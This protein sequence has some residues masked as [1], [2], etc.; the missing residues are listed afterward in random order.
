MATKKSDTQELTFN[1]FKS[2][3]LRDYKLACES[4]EMS[5]MGRREVLSGKGSFGIFGDGKELAQIA[6]ARCFKKGDFRSGYYR[7]QTL[8]MA[9]GEL[10]VQQFFA[11]LYGHADIDAEPQSGGRQMV[12]HFS[13]QS[14]NEDGSWKNLTEQ[15]NSASD[16]SCTAGQMPRLVGLA[17]ASKVYRENKDL[18]NKTK[19]SNNGSEI[20]FGTIGNSSCA[21]GHFF[22]AV[23]AIG[24][25]QVPAI[26]SV[27]DDGY[28]ISVG[29]EYQMT[30]SDVSE[31][32]KGFQRDEKGEGFEIF[33]VKG[34]DYAGLVETY[35]KAEKLAREEHVP[36]IVHVVDMTQPT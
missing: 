1:D 34:W 13:T 3:V 29:N 5:L 30:K 35:E 15:Y 11:A 6:L 28:G 17:Q 22:E 4:R 31:V 8:M 16:I 27:W 25:L 18:S 36:S 21:E 7:D 24:V 9:L 19:F 2:S 10:T 33:K 23:N 14:L 26:I 32:L 12:A 20:A